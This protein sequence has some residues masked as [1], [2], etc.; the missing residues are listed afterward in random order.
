MWKFIYLKYGLIISLLNFNMRHSVLFSIFKNEIPDIF[1]NCVVF[2]STEIR[3]T[4]SLELR[5]TLGCFSLENLYIKV[6]PPPRSLSASDL[7]DK[8]GAI[9]HICLYPGLYVWK[10]VLFWLLIFRRFLN[11]LT[12]TMLYIELTVNCERV[13]VNRCDLR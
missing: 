13:S 6:L 8:W 3:D 10:L 5:R 1:Y 4:L 9:S 12:Q 11:S 2:P 7:L